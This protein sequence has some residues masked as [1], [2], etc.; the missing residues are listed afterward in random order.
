MGWEIGP[1][2]TLQSAS[3]R[4]VILWPLHMQV[5]DMATSSNL[6]DREAET[7]LEPCLNA[8]R[9]DELAVQL[10]AAIIESSEDAIICQSL[11]GIITSWNRGAEQIFGYTSDEVIGQS[12]SILH[13]AGAAEEFVAILESIS[14]G[15]R[16][17]RF[18]TMRRRKDGT[19]VV[20]A[21]S[22]SPICDRQG[23]IIGASK[24]LRDKTNRVRSD[25]VFQRDEKLAVAG[26]L[27]AGVAHEINNPLAAVT[28]LHFLMKGEDLPERARR[29][30]ELA[31]HEL[32]RIS[33]ITTQA[34]GF[35][36]ENTEPV[37]AN[38]SE[39]VESAVAIHRHRLEING[40][41]VERRYRDGSAIVCHAGELKQVVVNLIG[42]AV[43][44]MPGGGTLWLR[45]RP[46]SDPG[47]T[48]LGVRISVADTGGGMAQETIR[49]LFE[50]FYTTKGSMKTGLG[51][52][53]CD[54]IVARHGGVIRVKSSESQKTHGSIVSVFLPSESGDL[55]RHSV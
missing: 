45:L 11:S 15:E 20:V 26:R 19:E 29:Y 25:A 18:E 30:L 51:L 32:T 17:R 1:S 28:N 37:E 13:P 7:N 54:Q 38:I 39:I 5:C 33:H 55:D 8:L 16:I 41:K 53:V 24:I 14:R 47:S 2:Y 43:D 50:P 40:I 21:L 12:I 10:L 36:Q 46:A 3:P 44:A 6:G 52:W 35:Y 23:K 31:D 34:L 4:D 22:I 9:D 42:N 48:R 27:A 49:R